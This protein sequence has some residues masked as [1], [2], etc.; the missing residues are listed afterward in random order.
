MPSEHRFRRF[1]LQPFVVMPLV[2]LVG[3]GAWWVTTRSDGSAAS[4]PVASSTAQLVT[5]TRGPMSSTVSAEGTVAAATT[6]NLSFTGSGTVTA[7]DVQ[8][9][10]TVK[11]GQVLATIDSSNLSATVASAQSALATAQAKLADDQAASASTEQLTADTLG[12]ATA[13][14]SLTAATQALAGAQ[15]V[16]TIDGTVASVNLTVGEVLGSGGTGGV[17][18][19]GSGSGRSS[20]T[21]AQSSGGTSPPG[22]SNTGAGTSSS[23]SA[24]TTPQIQVVSSGSFKVDL[25]VN[26]SDIAAVAVGQPA[27]VTVTTSSAGRSGGF[28]RGG[29][30][31]GGANGFG[32]NGTGGNGSAGG[33]TTSGTRA[34]AGAAGGASASGTVTAV[35]KVATATSG[36][37]T[38]TVTVS[39]EDTSNRIFIGSTVTGNIVTATRPDVVQVPSRAVTTDDS[40]STVRLAVDG[41]TTGKTETRTVT[42]GAT[43]SGQTEIT[44]GLTAGDKVVIALPVFSGQLP[45]GVGSNAGG[46]DAGGSNAGG[47]NVATRS[48]GSGSSNAGTGTRQSTAGNP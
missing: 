45:G 33:G 32:G 21:L 1:L 25:A 46:S 13:N 23:S 44:S 2:A 42:T 35:S 15:L 48:N 26:A 47:S 36:V 29:G 31:F 17:N 37:A 4:P 22:S 39:F 24:S 3:V 40:G 10:D 27:T 5:V 14:D 8:A 18:L 38:F 34:N 41:T 12:V 9:G 20:S 43:L 19:T 11:T 28:G 30:G 16:S 6:D 7:V